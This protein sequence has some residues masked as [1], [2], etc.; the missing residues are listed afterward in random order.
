MC[1]TAPKCLL[2]RVLKGDVALLLKRQQ[3]LVEI[4][5]KQVDLVKAYVATEEKLPAQLSS[6]PHSTVG[7]R[8]P[9]HSS[10]AA[11][12]S[13]SDRKTHVWNQ[14]GQ[15]ETDQEPDGALRP[16]PDISREHKEPPA[17]AAAS[18]TW[19]KH[20]LTRTDEIKNP[21]IQESRKSDNSS[22]RISFT[23]KA[24]DA[25]IQS[26]AEGSGRR[27]SELIERRLVSPGD[28]LQ[29]RLKVGKGLL[30]ICVDGSCSCDYSLL[31][32]S[33]RVASTRPTCRLMAG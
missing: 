22:A 21:E 15:K 17:A 3:T 32:C 31:V 18:V 4:F 19:R 14:N 33:C 27:L 24:G 25:L 6:R 20:T 30:W 11:T 5:Q 9:D 2:R 12:A 7:R 16:A 28:V 23:M 1:R 8:Q 13:V 29:L 26:S 10:T